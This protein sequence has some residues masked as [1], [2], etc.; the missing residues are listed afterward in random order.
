[1][2]QHAGSFTGFAGIGIMRSPRWGNKLKLSALP[3]V[4]A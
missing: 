2:Q 4:S 3:E 1:M